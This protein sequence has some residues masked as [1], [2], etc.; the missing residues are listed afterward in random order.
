MAWHSTQFVVFYNETNSRWNI[1][2]LQDSGWGTIIVEPRTSR[3]MDFKGFPW[4]TG[5]DEIMSRAFRFNKGGDPT[6]GGGATEFYLYQDYGSSKIFS[7]PVNGEP[8]LCLGEVA[9]SVNVFLNAADDAGNWNQ[10]VE[11][12]RSA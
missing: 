8:Q 3:H 12:V 6:S 2:D 11:V 1:V 7:L 4:C 5:R 9:N 10:S